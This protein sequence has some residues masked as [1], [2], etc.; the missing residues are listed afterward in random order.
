MTRLPIRMRLTAVYSLV[1]C[2]TSLLLEWG[3]Y[4]SLRGSLTSLVDG[5]LE[6]RTAGI[7]SFM[8]EHI[9]RMPLERFRKELGTHT[10]L[11]PEYL[12]ITD[13]Q[14]QSVWTSSRM[15][16]APANSSLRLKRRVA[17]VKGQTYR[18]EIASD[19]SIPVGILEHFRL[20]ALLSSPL[21]LACASL[22]GYSISKRALRPVDQMTRAARAIGASN[23]SA[24]LTVPAQ[25]DELQLLAQ[26]LNG[27]LSRIEDAFRQVTQFTAD[28]SHELRTPVAIVRSTA[29]VA[30][31]HHAPTLDTYRDALIHIL[32]ESEKNSLLL[33][34]MLRLARADAGGYK[35]QMAPVDL[36]ESLRLATHR[37]APLAEDKGIAISFTAA[38]NGTGI[39]VMADA[40]HL[41]R[42]WLILLDNAIK[43]TA[44]GGS[45]SVRLHASQTRA[46]CEL[47]DT[48]VG[49]EPADLP[50]IFERFYRSDKARN[51]ESGGVGLGLALARS[52]ADS[53][54]AVIDLDSTPG[55]GSAFRVSLPVFSV[56]SAAVESSAFRTPHPVMLRNVNRSPN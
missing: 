3:A 30:L 56:D 6:S 11:R 31:L 29:E 50:H 26:T 10:A 52:I 19:M 48:G 18:L 4:A 44:P 2:A 22:L 33:D 15:V 43:Y 14:G 37:L 16:N 46:I 5:E 32:E 54:N 35:L 27:M 9:P 7:V 17:K 12:A 1:F 36:S 45:V 47:K 38:P 42:L 20:L 21:V 39:Q 55:H 8:S 49:I 41:L 34:D 51:R 53:H 40:D 13:S 24:R 23:L 28:A 25:P